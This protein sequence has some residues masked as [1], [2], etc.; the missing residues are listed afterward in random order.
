MMRWYLSTTCC[1]FCVIYRH[2]THKYKGE[3]RTHN[4]RSL[5]AGVLGR[6]MAGG[7]CQLKTTQGQEQGPGNTTTTASLSSGRQACSGAS[8]LVPAAWAAP[9]AWR[10]CQCVRVWADTGATGQLWNALKYSTAFPVI[11][12]SAAKASVSPQDW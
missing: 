2:H 9:F 7:P 11:G 8:W 3:S 12:L 6:V 5:T 10:F 1:T 4:P